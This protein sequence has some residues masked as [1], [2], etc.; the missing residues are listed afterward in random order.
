MFIACRLSFSVSDGQSIAIRLQKTIAKVN[1]S[2]KNMLASYNE[3]MS[4]K[5]RRV[6]FV[7]AGNPDSG[8]YAC[9]EGNSLVGVLCPGH[10]IGLFSCHVYATV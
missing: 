1:A 9:V 6:A 4:E 7:D 8:L 3:L 10:A 2:L 5:S